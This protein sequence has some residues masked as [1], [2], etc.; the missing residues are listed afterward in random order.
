MSVRGEF[1]RVL[2]EWV[3]LLRA[4]ETEASQDWIRKL[5]QAAHSADKDLTGAAQRV[6]EDMATA[7]LPRGN[8]E[9]STQALAES[10]EHLTAIC[11]AIL[12]NPPR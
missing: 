3:T 7:E 6:L 9:L 11:H 5:E 8:T 10:A 4:T 12:G 2:A 1:K